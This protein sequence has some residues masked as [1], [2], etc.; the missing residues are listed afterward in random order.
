MDRITLY[1]TT[2]RDGMQ[3]EGMSLAVGEKLAIALRLAELGIDYIEA[4]FPSSNPKET[5]LFSLLER[6]DLGESRLAAFG[7]TRRRDSAADADPALRG[8]AECAAPVATIVGKTW[9]LHLEK[10][11]RV[12]RAE[13]LAIIEDHMR[14][15]GW[16]R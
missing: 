14:G 9:D 13:N 4:G 5:E 10:V 15:A 6:E 12:P 8:L 3:R 2:L 16:S 1:D 11:L 7:M